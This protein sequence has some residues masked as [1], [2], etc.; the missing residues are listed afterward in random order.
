MAAEFLTLPVPT[1]G[2]RLVDMVYLAL[3][4]AIA[5]GQLV[6]GTRLREVALAKHFGVSSTPVREAFRRLE[7]EGLILVSPHRGATVVSFT[8]HELTDLYEIHELLECRAVRRAA[9]APHHNLVPLEATLAEAEA[10]LGEPD[11]AAF[12]RLDLA[13][14]RALNDL[15]GNAPLA[16]LIEQV[17]RRIQSARVRYAGH[18]P[19]RPMHSHAQHKELLAAV[20]ARDPDRAEALSRAHIRAVRDAVVQILG[21]TGREG[22]RAIAGRY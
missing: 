2:G 14:H 17:H 19:G 10:I 12:N 8:L 13:F 7:R 11:Q 6:A 5:S 21:D 18:L 15:G 3:R 20:R 4:D 16:E 1:G 9:E 22:P